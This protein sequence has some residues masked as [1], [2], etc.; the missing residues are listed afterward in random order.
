M[1]QAIAAICLLAGCSPYVVS[2][3]TVNSE[4]ACPEACAHM[5]QKFPECPEGNDPQCIPGCQ[6]NFRLGYVWTDD[7]SGPLC[8]VRAT[9]KQQL[10]DCNV[11]CQTN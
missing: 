7:S 9:S 5:K 11:A 10:H 8:I 1:K 6:Q 3:T 4:T 2:P